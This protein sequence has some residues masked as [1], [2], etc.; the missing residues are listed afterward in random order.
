MVCECP[1]NQCEDCKE[2]WELAVTSETMRDVYAIDEHVGMTALQCYLMQCS[3]VRWPEM[4]TVPDDDPAVGRW[5]KIKNALK[6]LYESLK[7]KV[8]GWLTE[9]KEILQAIQYMGKI[10]AIGFLYVALVGILSWGIHKCV[11]TGSDMFSVRCGVCGKWPKLPKKDPNK[12]LWLKQEW[13]TLYD[14]EYIEGHVT[15]FEDEAALRRARLMQVPTQMLTGT[16]AAHGIYSQTDVRGQQTTR[17]LAHSIH[18]VNQHVQ[19]MIGKAAQIIYTVRS[20][21]SGDSREMS[22]VAVGGRYLMFPHHFF[23]NAREGECFAVFHSGAWLQEVFNQK[24]VVA[25]PNKDVCLYEMSARFHAHKNMIKHFISEK[26]LSY[27]IKA[28][29]TLVKLD[30]QSQRNLLFEGTCEAVSELEYELDTTKGPVPIKILKAYQYTNIPVMGGDCGSVLVTHSSKV[31]GV[32]LGIHIAGINNLGYSTLITR[33]HLERAISQYK[34]KVLLLGT[35]APPVASAH[36]S[37]LIPKGHFGRVGTIHASEMAIQ[38]AKTEI[39]PT[40]L[41]ELCFPH[42][43]EPSVLHRG[44]PRLVVR[45]SPLSKAISKYG[46]VAEPFPP[47]VLRRITQWMQSEVDGFVRVRPPQTLTLTQAIQGIP[48]LDGY[49]TLPMDTSPGWPYVLTRPRTEK[50]KDYLFNE[51][52][53]EIVD[54]TLKRKFE[55]RLAM[56]KLGERVES[57]WTDCLKDERRPIEKITSGSTRVFTIPPVDFCLLVRMFTMDFAE[58]V[59]NSR[60]FSFT[61]VGIDPQS[62]EWTFIWKRLASNSNVCM[63]GDFSRFDGTMPPEIIAEIFELIYYFYVGDDDPEANRELWN[64]LTVIRDEIV[65]T[66]T[67]ARDQVYVTHIGNPSGNP[68][69]VI[70]NS[71][72]NMYY[73]LAAW[74]ELTKTE[75]PELRTIPAFFDNVVPLVYGDD[76]LLSVRTEVTDF[77]NQETVSA[78]LQRFGIIYTNA[79]KSG[80]TKFMPLE[81]AT[82]LKNGFK[83]HPDLYL[84]K[85][86]TMARRTI[87]ELLNWTRKAPDQEALLEANIADALRF[88]YFH[89][90]EYFGDIRRR[91]VNALNELGVRMRVPVWSEYHAWFLAKCGFE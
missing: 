25:I 27:M 58:A 47:K 80:I 31:T 5:Q 67:L 86:P 65:H 64:V 36:C 46:N 91:V 74:L 81:E 68:L 70:I 33:E 40:I 48:E 9:H 24:R 90:K 77:F 62:L 1:E 79:E 83:D 61:Q 35:P 19:T 45:V 73:M 42:E 11:C 28:P 13:N 41:Y 87:Q 34:N 84:I 88:A 2:F 59:R 8:S 52:R 23:R 57:L 75:D 39:V 44:D 32:F 12:T 71:F 14:C 30:R 66:V 38:S 6:E 29:C 82:F 85:S 76:N 22:A 16:A 3:V 17:T 4:P 53:T 89:G 7:R 37:N 18:T 20:T 63:A 69:T 60:H 26:E 50:G 51:E 78:Y 49:M 56:A 54:Q 10:F 21:P 43:T 15:P 55:D 72:V